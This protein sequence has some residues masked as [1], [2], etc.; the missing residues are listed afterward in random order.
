MIN[1]NINT[2][3]YT[4]KMSGHADYA[5]KGTPDIVCAAASTLFFT[6][7]NSLDNLSSMCKFNIETKPQGLSFIQC[8]PVSECKKNINMIFYTIASGFMLLAENYPKH[9]KINFL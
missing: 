5:D 8:Q 7:A 4:L 1:V 3:Q 2:E 6:M 9:I